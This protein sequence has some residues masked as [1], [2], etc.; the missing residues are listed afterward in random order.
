[1]S[2]LGKGSQYSLTAARNAQQAD[3]RKHRSQKSQA[4]IVNAML[5]LVAEGNLEPSADQIADIAKVGRRSVFR[6]FKDM[7]TLYREIHNSIAATMGSIVLQPFT[8]ADWR[9]KVLELVDRR[10]MGFEKMKP[11]LLAGQVHRHRSEFLKVSHA[12]FVALL[13]A[14]LLGVLPKEAAANL[15]LVEALDMLLGFES[16]SRLREDQG[17]SIAKSKRVL[18]Q[19]IELLLEGEA[20]LHPRSDAHAVE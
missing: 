4:R 20:G 8:A 2:D 11:F 16:W 5:E 14:I 3:G 18:K 9:G 15:V 7:D 13:R 17:L 10:A 19:A 12:Q 6:H 1:M